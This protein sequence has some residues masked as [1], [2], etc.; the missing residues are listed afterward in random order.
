MGSNYTF[1]TDWVVLY[2]T[3]EQT[4][5]RYLFQRINSDLIAHVLDDYSQ[6]ARRRRLL[7]LLRRR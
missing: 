4:R 3:T 7:R 5:Q 2:I 1:W 6:N